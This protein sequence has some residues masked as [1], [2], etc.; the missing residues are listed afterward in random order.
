METTNNLCPGCFSELGELSECPVCGYSVGEPSVIGYLEPGTLLANRY[1]VGKLRSY[2]GEGANYFAFDR[3]HGTRC[4]LREYFPDKFCTRAKGELSPVVLPDCAVFYKTLLSEFTELWRNVAA[5]PENTD[6]QRVADVFQQ[7]G[8]AYAVLEFANR[9]KL[10]KVLARMKDNASWEEISDVFIHFCRTIA[11]VNAAGI[12]HRGISPETITVA[13]NGKFYLTGFCTTAARSTVSPLEPEIFDGYAAPEVF[14]AHS[15]NGAHTDT[16]SAAAVLYRL[17]TGVTPPSAAEMLTP[18]RDEFPDATVELK[19]LSHYNTSIPRVVSVAITSALTLS[20]DKRTPNA[21]TLVDKL[22]SDDPG[23]FAEEDLVINRPPSKEKPT[24]K[25]SKEKPKKIADNAP[26][27]AYSAKE[28]RKTQTKSF[29]VE[30]VI[31]ISLLSLALIALVVAIVYPILHPEVY[32]PSQSDTSTSTETD[33]DTTTPIVTTTKTSEST[34]QSSPRETVYV[35][36]NFVGSRYE[37]IQNSPLIL[38]LNVTLEYGYADGFAEGI[39]YEQ[40]VAPNT[41]VFENDNITLKVSKGSEYA[42]LPL[43]EELTVEMYA[44]QLSALKIKYETVSEP[45]KKVAAGF[46]IRASKKPGDKVN[47]AVGEMVTVYFSS[48]LPRTEP[49]TDEGDDPF[50]DD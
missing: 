19:P 44:E 7:N 9:P 16:Y 24:E 14:T 15:R 39:V 37:S 13:E 45:S 30:A 2:N 3:E 5:L 46:V 40:D 43:F 28:I 18:T 27:A 38:A 8:T 22:L 20:P 4:E 26:K 17:L 47:V 11:K 50:V 34:T 21:A 41:N 32:N 25:S 29:A 36:T 49:E 10:R 48:G 6:V 1:A 42:E 31:I 12:I 23:E 35:M 33:Y